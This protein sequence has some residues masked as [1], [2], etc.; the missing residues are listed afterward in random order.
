M[1]LDGEMRPKNRDIKKKRQDGEN[2]G[3]N[4]NGWP[5]LY[6]NETQINRIIS[7]INPPV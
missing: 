1:S 7:K 2:S 4:R 5:D 6:G 3:T